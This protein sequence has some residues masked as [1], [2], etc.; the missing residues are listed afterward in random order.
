MK[1]RRRGPS[2]HSKATKNFLWGQSVHSPR[3]EEGMPDTNE[4]RYKDS[5]VG[6]AD[7][8]QTAGN[9]EVRYLLMGPEHSSCIRAQLFQHLRVAVSPSSLPSTQ[10]NIGVESAPLEGHMWPHSQLIRGVHFL[11]NSECSHVPGQNRNCKCGPKFCCAGWL[12]L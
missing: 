10:L 5:S 4:M 9:T 2:L 3:F 12:D 6:A 1:L 7:T 8:L 11:F